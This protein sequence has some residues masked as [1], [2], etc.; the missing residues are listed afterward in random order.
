MNKAEARLLTPCRAGA[1]A[2]EWEMAHD[3]RVFFM[4]EDVVHMGGVFNT[5]TGLAAKFPGRILD[6]PISEEAFVGMAAGAA[7]EGMRPVVELAFADFLGVCVNPLMNY[8]AKTHYMSGGQLKVPMVMMVGAGG[9]Y[10]NGAEQSQCLYS[11]MAHCPGLKIVVP[12]NAYDTKG[13]VHAA[14]RD[15]DPVLVMYHKKTMG[16]PWLGSA[17]ETAINHVP[18][19]AYTVPIGTAQTVRE[20]RD[21]TLVGLAQTVHECL[22]AAATL[23]QDG[24]SAEV[25]DLRSVVPMDKAAILGSVEKTG[26]LIAVDEDYG[27]FG[28]TAEVICAVAEAGVALKAPPQRIAYP[29]VPPPA[30]RPMESFCLPGAAKIADAVRALV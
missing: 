12:S 20:G 9:G 16:V 17:P 23:E 13:L 1:E 26:R 4:G 5:A 24:I 28:V 7:I 22:A 11:L 21:V 30:A 2:V 25:I 19:D 27:N 29:D 10:N 15:D 8:A 14:I 3:E 18:N 6:T